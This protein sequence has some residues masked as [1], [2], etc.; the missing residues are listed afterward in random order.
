[1]FEN[2]PDFL[3]QKLSLDLSFLGN[4]HHL[5]FRVR[6][7]LFWSIILVLGL[8]L[9]VRKSFIFRYDATIGKV[10][11]SPNP[12]SLAEEG[13]E[14][15]EYISDNYKECK[16]FPVDY[17]DNHAVI[18][19]ILYCEHDGGLYVFDEL[20]FDDDWDDYEFSKYGISIE[21][22]NEI[23]FF[24]AKPH[25]RKWASDSHLLKME[26]EGT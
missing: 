10:V 6:M 20:I 7:L 4:S 19:G 5:E 14:D 11:V 17:P 22:D 13:E 3:G 2:L 1:M 23:I 26:I 25:W 18:D 12:E 24:P 9:V 15:P 16:S 21:T 8:I